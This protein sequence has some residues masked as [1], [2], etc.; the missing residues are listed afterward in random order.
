MTLAAV[1]PASSHESDLAPRNGARCYVSAGVLGRK[2][3]GAAASRQRHTPEQTISKLRETELA[4]G[5]TA[6]QVLVERWRRHYH[7]VGPHSFLGYRP[8]APEARQPWAPGL[9]PLGPPP[10]AAWTGQSTA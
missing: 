9:A 6:A 2:E 4:N 5:A 7:T 10:R 8:P 3:T 1:I